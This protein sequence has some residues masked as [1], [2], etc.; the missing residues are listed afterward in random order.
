LFGGGKEGYPAVAAPGECRA[1]GRNR[2]AENLAKMEQEMETLQRDLK[3]VEKSYGQNVLSL[4]VARSYIRKLLE[5]PE[6]KH[7]LNAQYADVLNE[8]TALVELESL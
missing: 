4:T 6:I 2:G 3:V 1:P 5:N 8:I 7:F